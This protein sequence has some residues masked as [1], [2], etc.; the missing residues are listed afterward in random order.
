[1]RPIISNCNSPTN[2]LS[3]FLAK[4]L[5]P[6]LGSFS[7]SHLRHNADLLNAIKNIIPGDDKFIS[8]DVTAPFTNVPL[9][10]TLHFLKRKLTDLRLDL[11][12]SIDCFIEFN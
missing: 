2:R 6:T 10:P 7:R 8:F 3:K 12:V 1:M 11:E 9:E 5:S 4:C